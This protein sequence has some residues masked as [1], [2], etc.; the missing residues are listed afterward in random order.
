VNAGRPHTAIGTYGT[1]GIRPKG[2]G[3]I[4]TARYRDADGRLRPATASWLCQSEVAPG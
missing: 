2:R 4:A 1:I 3:Y